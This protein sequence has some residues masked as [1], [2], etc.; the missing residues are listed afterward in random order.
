MIWIDNLNRTT[1]MDAIWASPIVYKNLLY[2]G[3]ASQ[4]DE[5]ERA[6]KGAIYAIYAK[7]A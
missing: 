5:S 4:G 1:L 7:M 3:V 2:I 6:W